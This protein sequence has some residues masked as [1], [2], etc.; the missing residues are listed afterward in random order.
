MLW[1]A[2]LLAEDVRFLGPSAEGV[3]SLPQLAL[4]LHKVFTVT[5]GFMLASGAF[6][7][8]TVLQ[9]RVRANLMELT[10]LT[11][12]GV[13]GVGLMCAV[14]FVIDSDFKWVLS[15]PATVWLVALIA[16]SVGR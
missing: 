4:W 6:T 15:V 5:G 7:L 8:N 9:S 3:R 14:N 13:T 12:A 10:T 11:F 16:R 2:P 1:R